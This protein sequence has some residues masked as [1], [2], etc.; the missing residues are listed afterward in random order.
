MIKSIENKYNKRTWNI[1]E[2]EHNY[3]SC[4]TQDHD[5]KEKHQEHNN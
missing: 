1:I 2:D 5:N 4:R 3:E